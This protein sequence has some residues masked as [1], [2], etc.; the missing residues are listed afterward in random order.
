MILQALKEYYDRKAADP[1]SGIAPEGWEWKEIPFIAVIDQKGELVQIEDTRE[2][3]GKR[4][5]AKAFLVPLGEKKASGI[6]ANLLWDT[7]NY[8]LG[9]AKVDELKV[10]EKQRILVKTLEQ[11]KIFVERIQKELADTPKKAALLKFLTGINKERLEKLPRWNELYQ[12]KPNITFRFVGEQALYCQTE[13]VRSVVN[14]K[15]AI[16][17]GLCLVSGEKAKISVLH[18]AIKGVWGAQSSGANIVS[19]NLDSFSSYGKRGQ[20]GR[21]APIGE[22]AMFAY[23]TAL[24]TLLGKDSRQRLQ[25]GDA[26]TVFWSDKKT[27]FENDFLKFF[28]EPPKD[29]PDANTQAIKD[30]FNSVNTGAYLEDSGKEKF[31]V[32]GL[33]PN[34]S[35]IAIRFWAV[36]T[37]GEF[38]G[39]IRQH[40]EDLTI[41]KPVSINE[42]DHYSLWRILVNIA[43]QNKSENIPPNIAGDFMRTVLEGR[44]YP[45]TLLQA[46]IRRIKSD[47]E[48]R[49]TPVRAALIKAYLNRQLRFQKK[50]EAKEVTMSLDR[51]QK[52]RG[53]V[54]G[55][56]FAVLEKIQE[57]AGL[58]G[59]RER[60][61]GAACG[62]PVTVFPTLLRL[63]NHHIVK[64]ENKGRAVNMEK[65]ISEI[66][67]LIPGGDSMPYPAHFNLP[68]QGMFAVGYYHQ[69][70][71]LFTAK[72]QKK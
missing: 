60:Y 56:L 23:T 2:N 71:D 43:V 31:F 29:N 19:F 50:I 40:F 28:A 35:R 68:E 15:E 63:K 48:R 4:K 51:E 30:L 8:A 13:E 14:T 65:L 16:E 6:K 12:T 52:S 49:V 46:A 39:K 70:Q 18:T 37:V 5:R 3:E 59:I 66:L 26:S 69:R 61:Y 27:N 57:E 10:A 47:S 21:N 34:A 7:V 53:Y 41:V 17:D 72:E 67:S 9:I 32:L 62:A 33:A 44:P 45:V 38:A 58:S 22:K 42:P 1:E 54:L 36:G 55:R 20:Q 24:N 11:K 25:V 64:L